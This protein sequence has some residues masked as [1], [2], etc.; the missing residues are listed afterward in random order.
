MDAPPATRQ[1]VAGVLAPLRRQGPQAPGL[2]PF[3][4]AQPP[5]HSFRPSGLRAERSPLSPSREFCV[6]LDLRR[7]AFALSLLAEGLKLRVSRKVHAKAIG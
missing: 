2:R 3:A 6:T 4:G 7:W 5:R 1:S